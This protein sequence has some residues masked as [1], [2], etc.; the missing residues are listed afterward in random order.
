MGA[1]N[2]Q[3][4]L[5]KGQRLSQSVLWTLQRRFFEQ[6]GVTA[7]SRG[8][9]PHYITT[10]P[11]VAAA[12]ARLVLGW[13]R[14]WKRGDPERNGFSPAALDGSQCVYVLELGAGA[15]RFAYHFLR[16]YVPLWSHSV[17][18][19][20]PVKYVMTDFADDAVDFWQSHPCLRPYVEARLL[21]FA[22]FDAEHDEEI[23]LSVS[24]EVLAAGTVKNPLAVIGNY[25]L[26]SIPHDAFSI[27]DGKLHECRVSLILPNP[28]TDPADP[29]LLNQ[30]HLEFEHVPVEGAYYEEPDWNRVL[31]G[32]ERRLSNTVVTFPV[33]GLRCLER[34]QGFCGNRM[35]FLCSDKGHDREEELLGREEAS[36]ALHGSFSL[37]V[38]LHA[39][40]EVVRAGDGDYLRPPHA[41][42]H[43]AVSAFLLGEPADGYTE[44]RQAFEENISR[45]GP[46][47][48]YTL[49]KGIETFFSCLKLEQL[50]AYLCLSG[51]DANI[52]WRCS[53]ELIQRAKTAPKPAQRELF[54]AARQVWDNYFP[55]GEREDLAA[56][57]GELMQALGRHPDA[58]EYYRHSLRLHGPSATSYCGLARSHLALGQLEQADDCAARARVVL[59][60]CGA[61]RALR[62][63]VE[64]CRRRQDA[65]AIDLPAASG[66]REAE[67]SA[68]VTN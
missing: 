46:D 65:L 35:L 64:E 3:V 38:N 47:E 2:P 66:E 24:G 33:A 23:R 19:S 1:G 7:W 37:M 22:R 36:L 15:G 21:D 53:E 20:V 51:W 63:E 61:A 52:F 45:G 13:L 12:Y 42:A 68:Y 39:V 44:T 43:L 5:E 9:V 34:L 10:N 17:L 14:D 18:K 49:K 30:L 48:V 6:R 32:Y 60:D 67:G 27:R 4:V 55:I 29:D 56:C 58:L 28:V 50:L 62:I 16:Q 8:T 54:W 57:L 59:P 25:F 41:H 26:D 11:T 40:G 31:L